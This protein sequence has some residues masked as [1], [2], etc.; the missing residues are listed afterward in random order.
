MFNVAQVGVGSRGKNTLDAFLKCQDSV[1]I[2]AICN[3]NKID[4]RKVAGQFDISACFSNIEDLINYAE[5]DFACSNC[6]LTVSYTNLTRP[7]K[8]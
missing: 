4:L 7:T 6:L 1:E 5:S 8:S 3:T 2:M